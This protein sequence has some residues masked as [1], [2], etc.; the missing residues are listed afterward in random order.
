MIRKA[1]ILDIS[2]LIFMLNSMHKETELKIPKINTFILTNKI[3]EIL[4]K[5][6]VLVAVENNKILGSIAGM[7]VSDWWSDEK[8]LAD[9]W[10]Y[11]FPDSRKSNIAKNL[12]IDFMKIA[13]E[14]KLKIRL[15]HAFSGDIARKDKFYEKL[16]LVK[17]GSI[18]MEN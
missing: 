14:A 13:K 4:H 17:A 18:Y 3:N 8:Y 2:A 12:I 1:N 15:G 11:V 6:I 5:G 16:G 9:S 7:A 10:F